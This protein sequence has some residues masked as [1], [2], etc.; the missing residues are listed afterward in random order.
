MAEAAGCHNIAY[1]SEKRGLKRCFPHEFVNAALQSAHSL[2]VSSISACAARTKRKEFGPET[3]QACSDKSI[4]GLNLIVPLDP[5]K[6]VVIGRTLF[7][8]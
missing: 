4:C 8:E 6:R 7:A 2:E 3:T 1:H 5:E